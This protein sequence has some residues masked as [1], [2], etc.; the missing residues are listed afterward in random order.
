LHGIAGPGAGSMTDTSHQ[1]QGV[2]DV[3]FWLKEE[4]APWV[5]EAPDESKREALENVLAHREVMG[6]EYRRRCADAH[7]H[8]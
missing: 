4:F 3:S 7:E 5:E 1:L 2:I 6:Q 8:S